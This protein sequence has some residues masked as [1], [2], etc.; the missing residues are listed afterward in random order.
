ME[1]IS[2]AVLYRNIYTNLLSRQIH[3]EN[4]LHRLRLSR[5]VV[6]KTFEEHLAKV[7]EKVEKDRANVQKL[8]QLLV[9]LEK[10]ETET[11]SKGSF[12]NLSLGI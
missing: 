2:D 4:R 11:T 5:Q 8:G 10:K 12:K 3:A 1:E 6:D 7:Q 9:V